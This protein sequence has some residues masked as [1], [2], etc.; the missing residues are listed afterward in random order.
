MG[1]EGEVR[2][3]FS[4]LSRRPRSVPECSLSR[5]LNIHSTFQSVEFDYVQRHMNELILANDTLEHEK[6][7]RPNVPLHCDK[8]QALRRGTST[9]LL[10]PASSAAHQ[11]L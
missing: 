10:T 4:P 1:E 11:Q 2:R 5:A 6:A 3:Y 8:V 7:R 9:K